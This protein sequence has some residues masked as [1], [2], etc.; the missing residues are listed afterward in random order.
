MRH[1]YAFKREDLPQNTIVFDSTKDEEGFV[2][3]GYGF[4]PMDREENMTEAYKNCTDGTHYHEHDSIP[5]T[6]RNPP[7][8]TTLFARELGY[9]VCLAIADRLLVLGLLTI[10]EAHKTKVLLLA[11]YRPLIGGLLA[12]AG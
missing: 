1:Q 7:L 9:Q 10:D 11:K 3:R 4:P 6:A 5:T 2:Y 12:E 8:N